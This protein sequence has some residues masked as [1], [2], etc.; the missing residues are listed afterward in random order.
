MKDLKI[1]FSIFFATLSISAIAGGNETASKGN[2]LPTIG[3][4]DGALFFSGDVGKFSLGEPLYSRNGIYFEIQKKSDSRLDASLFILSGK[5]YGS[6]SSP[7]RNLNF[8]SSI[9]AEGLNFRYHFSSDKSKT[10]IPFISAGIE[11]LSF[12]TK[13]DL[14]DA[15]GNK[16]YFWTDGTIRNTDESS[17]NASSAVILNRDYN[18]ETDLHTANLDGRTSYP[19]SC[20]AFPVG[21]GLKFRLSDKF[22]IRVSAMYHLTNSDL[23][24]G[25]DANGKGERQGSS[26]NDKFIYTSASLHFDLSGKKSDVVRTAQQGDK[27]YFTGKSDYENNDTDKDGVNDLLDECPGTPAGIKVNER[28]CPIDSDYDGVPDYRD[29]EPNSASGAMADEDGIT[30]TDKLIEEKF[31]RDSLNELL[32]HQLEM[33][34]A[35]DA[36]RGES[37]NGTEFKTEDSTRVVVSGTENFDNSSRIPEGFRF[38]DTDKNGFISPA[39][40]S[41]AIDD[42]LKDKSPLDTKRFHLLIDFF[43]D[44]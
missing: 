22:H 2:S 39:E 29:K 9:T 16:Y 38:V 15:S 25:I 41:A 1:Y 11:F 23:I 33:L 12:N 37:F 3:F 24:D 42:Y 43:F 14:Y 6:I 19:T 21:A 35:K 20:L 7:T 27:N 36:S 10:C 18:Y 44:Q 40:M 5:L 26:G 34:K 8:L 13:S 30:I 31:T 32:S 17:A 4:G 28:G